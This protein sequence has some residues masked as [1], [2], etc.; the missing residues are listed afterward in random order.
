MNH[1]PHVT[2]T[3]ATTP[4]IGRPSPRSPRSPHARPR[5]NANPC[6]TRLVGLARR[7]RARAPLVALFFVTLFWPARAYPCAPMYPPGEDVAIDHEKALIVWDEARHVEHFVRS[8]HFLTTGRS[9]GFLVP[10]PSPPTLGE[11]DESIFTYLY[12]TTQQDMIDQPVWGDQPVQCTPVPFVFI[13]PEHEG[14][15]SAGNP[16]P[17]SVLD[18]IHVAGLDATVL[19]ATDTAALFDWLTARGFELREAAKRWLA[20]YVAK[21][22]NIVAFRYE[23]P[24]SAAQGG[25]SAFSSGA[26]RISFSTDQPVYPYR[27]PDDVHEQRGR[28]LVLFVA[29]LRGAQASL[30]DSGDQPWGATLR[31]SDEV[32]ATDFKLPGVELPDRIWLNE[33][34]DPSAKRPASDVAFRASPSSPVVRRPPLIVHTPK[35]LYVPYELVPLLAAIVWW[36]RRRGRTR[37]ARA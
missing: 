10:T 24:A 7:T 31:F 32:V 26:V 14:W 1:Y 23:A 15:V 20:V 30:V 29:G 19:A 22:W 9:F 27:E 34:S 33:F 12:T 16:D 13:H 4:A 17:V 8:A 5:R 35:S 18:T 2:A 36:W 6:L 28:G 25:G 11:V 37:V 21:K 3:R